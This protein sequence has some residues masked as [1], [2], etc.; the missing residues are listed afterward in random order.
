MSFL[1]RVIER[2]GFFVLFYVML[3]F[4]RDVLVE[5]IVVDHT[6]VVIVFL[7]LD[8]LKGCLNALE[9]V[10]RHGFNSFYVLEWTVYLSTC[11]R[12]LMFRIVFFIQL[13]SF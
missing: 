13:I 12:I 4:I 5:P 3:F 8:R 2:K 6:V 9:F 11:N 10:R 1:R 7:R